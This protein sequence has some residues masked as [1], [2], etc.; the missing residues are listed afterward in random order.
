MS[1]QHSRAVAER[2]ARESYGKLVAILAKRDGDIAGAKDAL[3]EAFS[4]AL[5]VWP[6]KGVPKTPD[7][8]LLTVA[9]NK[10]TDRMRSAES[11]LAQR[12]GEDEDMIPDTNI[13]PPDG[14]R[15]SN[16]P[17]ERLGLMFVCA[18][19]AID[20]SVHTPLMMQ[21]VLGFEAG[22]IA[23]AYLQQPATLSQRLVRA[24]RK[25]KDA[26]IPF[27]VPDMPEA[28]GRVEPVLEAIY[29][30]LSLLPV[31]PAA[32]GLD[33]D[34]AGEALYLAG[35]LADQMPGNAEALGLLALIC[36]SLSRRPA[37]LDASGHFVPLEEQD[38]SLWDQALLSRGLHALKTAVSLKAPGRFQIEA[39]IQAAHAERL[40][41]GTTN[42]SA[43]VDLYGALL[44]F[45]RS[46]GA[47]CAMASAMMHAHGPEP[48]LRLLD[49]LADESDPRSIGSF[50]PYWAA[51][52]RALKMSGDN[53]AAAADY[54]KAISLA[55]EAPIRAWLEAEMA[56][57]SA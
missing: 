43:I 42:W 51:R 49:G 2:A 47:V 11:R 50:Q 40:E 5:K 39:A 48:A 19:P 8:W 53:Q 30:V 24:K 18:H 17:D 10:Q 41:T 15:G 52:A 57:L 46:T 23:Q 45:G 3:A 12:L 7:A 56:H 35:V 6:E 34:M 13:T 9:K 25:I 29:G 36:L 27:I 28:E 26:R 31:V 38:V 55:T 1:H 32:G 22:E 4:Q 14:D 44:S 20:R 21:T 54:E 33:N 16:M 37:R